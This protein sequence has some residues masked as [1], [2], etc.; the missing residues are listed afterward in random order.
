MY[1]IELKDLENQ[2][3]FL[4]IMKYNQYDFTNCAFPAIII[5]ANTWR[6]V[7]LYSLSDPKLLYGAFPLSYGCFPHINSNL[8]CPA[9]KGNL[10]RPRSTEGLKVSNDICKNEFLWLE[11]FRLVCV[12][13]RTPI[14]LMN[15]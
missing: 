3:C 2:L 7:I 14:L 1:L 15:F 12:C 5:Q 8:H 6:K 4:L 9:K 13:L 11:T 10:C